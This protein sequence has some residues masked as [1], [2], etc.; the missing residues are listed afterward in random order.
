MQSLLTRV[1]RVLAFVYDARAFL[2]RGLQMRSVM[3]LVLFCQLAMA[4]PV[5]FRVL[6]EGG[7]P[8]NDVLV[9]VQNLQK[10]EAELLRVLSDAEGNAGFREL[11][12]GLYRLIATAPYG[13]WRTT[14]KE[15]LVKASPMEVVLRVKVM[16]T[17]GWGDIVIVGS[18]WVDLH[19]LR[20]DG[21]PASGAELLVRDRDATLHMERW[22]K[23]DAQGRARIEMVSDPLVLVVLYQDAMMTTELSEHNASKVIKFSPD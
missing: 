5:K 15:F 8:V 16:P 22:Y 2:V 1:T 18:P 19:V 4:V 17:H 11:E 6:D 23:T 10:H 12:P 9:I 7:T 14:I 21:Q 13:L 20:P 3:M